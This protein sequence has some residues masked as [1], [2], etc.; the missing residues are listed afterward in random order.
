MACHTRSF[1]SRHGTLTQRMSSVRGGPS[2][3]IGL[4]PVR[5]LIIG[6]RLG[7]SLAERRPLCTRPCGSWAGAAMAPEGEDHVKGQACLGCKRNVLR[8]EPQ[9]VPIRIDD[10]RTHHIQTP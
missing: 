10:S 8:L 7:L 5:V 3:A 9:T 2:D 1:P 6:H 4:P